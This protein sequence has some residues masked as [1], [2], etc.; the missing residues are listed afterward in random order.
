MEKPSNV[1]AL[2]L[3]QLPTLWDPNVLREHHESSSIGTNT[4]ACA[5]IAEMHLE[6]KFSAQNNV[7]S[8]LHT[9]SLYFPGNVQ[10]RLKKKI[11]K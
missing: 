8:P 1:S 11:K 6:F 10:Q 9:H 3:Q 4:E 5:V 2:P 7:P